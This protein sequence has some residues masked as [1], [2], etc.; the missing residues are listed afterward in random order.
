MRPRQIVFA[1]GNAGKAR[2]IRAMFSDLWGGEVELIL[3]GELDVESVEETGKTFLENAL[4]KARH[5]A[6]ETGLPA[7]ADDSGIEVDALNGAPGVYS[8][9]FAGSDASDQDNVDKL[10]QDLRNVSGAERSARFRCVLV[11]VRNATDDDPLVADG[12]WEGSIAEQQ[13]GSDGFGYD[14]VFVDATSGRTAAELSP[15]QKNARS[16]R[17]KALAALRERLSAVG[18]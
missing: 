11:Y 9:R 8:S 12:A 1:S 5:A 18:L 16:H 14:P 15:E 7:L 4:L 17:G 6:S 2:E 13:S 10:L 3:Q